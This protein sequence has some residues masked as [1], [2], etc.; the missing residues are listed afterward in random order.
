MILHTISQ[1]CEI[2]LS[3]T[4]ATPSH[5]VSPS[6]LK[7]ANSHCMSFTCHYTHFPCHV[8]TYDGTKQSSLASLHTMGLNN[9]LSRHYIRW[10]WN[11][12]PHMSWHTTSWWSYI[13]SPKM[14]NHTLS[15]SPTMATLSHIVSYPLPPSFSWSLPQTWQH[16]SHCMSFTRHYT[17]FPCHVITYDGTKIWWV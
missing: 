2:I 5:I 10:T 6:L 8:I 9:H 4:M 1:K 7:N 12:I 15:F 13:R 3:P 17:H 14:R 11:M 16:I